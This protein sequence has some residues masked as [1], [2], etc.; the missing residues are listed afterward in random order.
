MRAEAD[1]ITLD[2]LLPLA[3]MRFT[4]WPGSAVT[5][6]WLVL[7]L[8]GGVDGSAQVVQ[9]TPRPVA[10]GV[11]VTRAPKIDGR[12]DDSVWAE[13]QPITRFTQ[14]EPFDGR[15]ATERTEVRI[16][17]D[18]RAIY[19]GARL[20]DSD[21]S[22]I[23]RGQVRRDIDLKEQDAFVLVFD[24]YHDHQNG[25]VFAT[26]P[27]GIEHDGQVTKEG[28][29]GFG[30]PPTNAPS[31][32]QGKANLNWDGTW[33]VATSIDSLGWVAEFRIPFETL[34]YG[35]GKT[36]TWGLNLARYIRRKSEEDFWAA[37]PRQH[38]LYRVSQ[39]GTLEGLA[40]PSQRLRVITPYVLGSL[41]RD[42]TKATKPDFDAQ[43][44]L[45]AKIGLSQ[46]MALDL[47]Y[48]TDFAQVEA[49][50]QQVNLTRF[51][52]FFPE[53]RPFFLENAGT[54]A[55]GTPQSVDLF[56]SR[57]I[58]IDAGGRQVPILG[59][60]RVTGKAGAL[61]LGVLDVQT[62]RLEAA[63]VPV[64]PMNNYSVGRLIYE[65]PHRSRIGL[66]AT[67]R[68]NTDSTGDYNAAIGVDGTI[69]IGDAAAIDL[70]A[71]HSITPGVNASANLYNVA[72]TYNTRQWEVSGAYRQ[73]DDGF[74]PEI[75]FLER[76]AFRFYSA[77]ALRHLRTPHLS[78]FREFRPHITIR[79]FDDI[80]GQPQSRLL[81]FDSH[82]AFANGAF[83]ESPF[84]FTREAL[85]APFQ[86]S[87]HVV[88]PVG[89]YD[90]V[91]WGPFF[92]TNLSAPYSIDGSFTIGGFYTGHQQRWSLN[93]TAR[94][95][96]RINASMRFS[97]ANVDLREG[98]FDRVLAV[99]SSRT[100]SPRGSTSTVSPSIATRTT[101]SQ[102]TFVSDGSGPQ[103]P[104]SSSSTMK[105]AAPGCWPARSSGPS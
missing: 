61:T 2:P 77:R 17:Y 51:N 1:D 102:P 9:G 105:D 97:Y 11:A 8:V 20:Y 31:T 44:G 95:N 49:D 73:V 80:D 28:E 65:L 78:W 27:A 94:P 88:I 72:A 32:L 82:F 91:E 75:G 14:H 104:V 52:L 74:D 15:D 4:L 6:S 19:I 38:S 101:A 25:F 60:G 43:F 35:S 99:L 92:N 37:I 55:F 89:V 36:Q 67:N 10:R 40:P 42:Y 16:L 98:S 62:D 70:Y 83:F 23:I 64:T 59:G 96:R 79:Q 85:R 103:A 5:V 69:G 90:N 53:K 63:G 39:A 34:R 48:N 47:T 3:S 12:L 87:K 93:F 71:A 46:S 66:I 81:H 86:I 29:G 45:D 54:F 50:E 26:T 68:L 7:S 18:S 30:G 100:H 13:S 41:R 21:P 58:G 33:Q 56:F 57:Q 84:N 22:G 76:P 24:T